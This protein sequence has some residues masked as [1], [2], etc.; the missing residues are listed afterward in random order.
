MKRYKIKHY[1]FLVPMFIPAF[2]ILLAIILYYFNNAELNDFIVLFL[3][4]ILT[5]LPLYFPIKYIVQ[6][7][8]IIDDQYIFIS[9]VFL[10][11]KYKKFD[12]NDVQLGASDKVIKISDSEKKAML[13]KHHFSKEDWESI[14]SEFRSISNS[15]K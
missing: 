11:R 3:L 2:N 1:W 15:K 13:Y 10:L 7:T 9:E 4:L 6:D 5:L 14:Y 12:I 8:I